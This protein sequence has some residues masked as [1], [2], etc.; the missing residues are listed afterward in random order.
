MYLMDQR[1]QDFSKMLMFLPSTLYRKEDL[2]QY[3]NNV[4]LH[5]IDVSY[6]QL[7]KL[8]EGNEFYPADLDNNSKRNKIKKKFC[9]FP[10]DAADISNHNLVRNSNAFISGSEKI[11]PEYEFSWINDSYVKFQGKFK[12]GY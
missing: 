12:L 6:D 5:P 7:K 1:K 10:R 8:N 3:S 11:D 2:N 4:N 9:F